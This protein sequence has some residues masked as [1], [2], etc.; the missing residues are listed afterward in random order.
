M[1][2]SQIQQDVIN[3]YRIHIDKN[4]QCWRR[5]HAHIKERRVCKWDQRNSIQ[6]TFTL[7]HEVGHIETKKSYMRRCE[8]EYYATKW[9]LERC[10]EYGIHVP[11]SIIKK[12]QDYIYRELD[13]GVRRGGQLPSREAMTLKT[14]NI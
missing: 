1:T 6:S 12:Y 3:K 7:L 11:E 4:S 10:E 5:T 8:S 2:Y 9:A 13:R 14:E